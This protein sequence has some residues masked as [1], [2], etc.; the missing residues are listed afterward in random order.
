MHLD[1]RFTLDQYVTSKNLTITSCNQF[2]GKNMFLRLCV[3]LF[4]RKKV[5]SC[6]TDYR[7]LSSVLFNEKCSKNGHSTYPN[8]IG[9]EKSLEQVMTTIA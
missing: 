5:S 8:V 6:F 4:E 1:L 9:A 7:E 2:S 3:V